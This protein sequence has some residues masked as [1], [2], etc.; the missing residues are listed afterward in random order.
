[1]P[2]SEHGPRPRSSASAPSQ[3]GAVSIDK[4]RRWALDPDSNVHRIIGIVVHHGPLSRTHLQAENMRRDFSKNP[5]GAIASLLT[6][7]G[8][9]YGRVFREQGGLLSVHPEIEGEVRKHRWAS[10]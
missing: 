4:I 8:N 1:M 2:G 3:E 7:K 5:G 9:S 6:N 10:E